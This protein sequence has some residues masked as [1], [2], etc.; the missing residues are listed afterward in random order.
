MPP[1]RLG[2]FG[3]TGAGTEES[4]SFLGGIFEM[5]FFPADEC[6]PGS[7]DDMATLEINRTM[8]VL[9]CV[10]VISSGEPI[11]FTL[12]DGEGEG[13]MSIKLRLQLTNDRNRRFQQL[14]G[15][16]MNAV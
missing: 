8:D 2:F 12:I 4:P 7:G 5:S 14:Y 15:D 9:T 3:G 16:L 6:P 1:F 10:T 13:G 11:T